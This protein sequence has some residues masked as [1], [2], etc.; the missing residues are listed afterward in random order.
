MNSAA[1]PAMDRPWHDLAEFESVLVVIGR[2]T[3]EASASETLMG[4]DMR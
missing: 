2:D 1:I 3:A 4:K